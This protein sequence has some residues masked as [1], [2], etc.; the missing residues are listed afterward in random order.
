MYNWKKF[1]F[2]Y[3]GWNKKFDIINPDNNTIKDWFWKYL[4]TEETNASK[5]HLR[6]FF[7]Q[8]L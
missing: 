1:A 8:M 4:W 2:T 7:Q 3:D 5:K 6:Y